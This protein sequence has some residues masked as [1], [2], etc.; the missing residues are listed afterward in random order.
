MTKRIA[1][2]IIVLAAIAIFSVAAYDNFL[3][4]DNQEE[5]L[6][7]ENLEPEPSENVEIIPNA[8]TIEIISSKHQPHHKNI[9]P[10]CIG[11]QFTISPVDL[12]DIDYITPLGNLHPPEHTLP[13][14]HMYFHLISKRIELK[15]PADITITSLATT[16][17]TEEN[18]QDYSMTFG[19]CKDVFGYFI[20]VKEVAP[21]LAALI[22]ECVP[23]GSSK[24][25]YCWIDVNFGVKAGEFLG[26]VGNDEQGNFDFGAYDFRTR[27]DYVNPSRYEY[28]GLE[29]SQSLSVT[30][31]LELYDD[32]TKIK[33]YEKVQRT[34]EPKCGIVAQDVKGTIQGN[35]FFEDTKS[36]LPSDWNKYLSFIHDNNDPSKSVIS[37]GG[38]FTESG[39]WIFVPDDSG[40]V[41][42][43]FSDVATD[44]NIYC[45]QDDFKAGRII[46]KLVS[47]TE[48][49]IE[50]QGGSCSKVFVLNNPT[51]YNL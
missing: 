35:W 13:T 50:H 24:Y 11:K 22:P 9:S 2:T 51:V 14:E 18:T 10:D 27:L 41:N 34:T 38:I 25:H 23:T 3:I 15:A 8:S 32:E 1:T 33:L 17:N 12:G 5:F 37:I 26:K 39:R 46:V 7:E 20:H 44:G 42:R 31:P 43:K 45:Y 21:S 49:K 6:L 29:R 47:E 40:L 48:L 28:P 30:C 16:I 19:L 36:N 4:S